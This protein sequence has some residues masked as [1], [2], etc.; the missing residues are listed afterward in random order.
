MSVCYLEGALRNDPLRR[1][2]VERG[3]MTAVGRPDVQA[4]IE[5][6]QAKPSRGTYKKAFGSIENFLEPHESVL[7]IA[8]GVRGSGFLGNE[9]A[10]MVLTDRKL[11]V[12]HEGVAR[13]Q[14]EIVPLDLITAVAVEKLLRWAAI[15]TTGAQSNESLGQVNPADADALATE[16][17]ALLADRAR[18]AAQVTPPTQNSV[19]DELT[20][21]ATLRDQGI[22]TDEEFTAQKAR[23]LGT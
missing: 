13:H 22:L 3:H 4:A 23:L 14:H 9:R 8:A 19:A 10:L 15:K 21:L 7:R 2:C 6:M 16:L 11:L 20:K 18:S 1:T 5:K 17:R 12:I